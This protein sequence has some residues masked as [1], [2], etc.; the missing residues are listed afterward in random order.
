MYG[1]LFSSYTVI[2]IALCLVVSQNSYA[3]FINVRVYGAKAN[4]IT[5]DTRA[6]LK[7]LASLKDN[8]TL[9]FS[10][11]FLV[12][13]DY[14][15]Q[16]TWEAAPVIFNLPDKKITILGG[17]TANFILGETKGN[18]LAMFRTAFQSKKRFEIKSIRI[19]GTGNKGSTGSLVDGITI[20]GSQFGRYSNINIIN[21]KRHGIYMIYGAN[22]NTLK[23]ISVK[24]TNREMLGCGLQLEGASKNIF[25]GIQLTDI[26]ANGIDINKW[27]CGGLYY[28]DNNSPYH[29]TFYSIGN[30]FNNV[31][32]DNTGV[33]NNTFFGAGG[34]CNVDDDYYG[35]NIING[36]DYNS[37]YNVQVKNVRLYTGEILPQKS[38]YR[39]ALRLMSVKNCILNC[40]KVI[41]STY[42]A[43][44][45]NTSNSV[46]N[47]KYA[48][49]TTELLSYDSSAVTSK[50]T[51]NKMLKIK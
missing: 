3:R 34:T 43:Y 22:Y 9:Y 21:T 49:A 27:H 16:K 40:T 47:V 38:T 32:I 36:S 35:I 8:D 26:G 44:L 48:E 1:K 30:K 42:I 14:S 7:A 46:I 51:V 50:F 4:G 45:H 2:A 33:N 24:G 20:N 6:I 31:I 13:P 11:R 12:T 41:N 39:A 23:N 5:D 25:D 18:A 10:G 15:I 28:C 37:L 17:Q 19:I 29:K